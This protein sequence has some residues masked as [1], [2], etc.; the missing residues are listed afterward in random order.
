[1]AR[2]IYLLGHE[3]STF[4]GGL[5]WNTT[6][7][8]FYS[9]A[10]RC[11]IKTKSNSYASISLPALYGDASAEGVWFH[12]VVKREYLQDTGGY[13]V[14]MTTPN[15]T[16]MSIAGSGTYGYP[17][18]HFYPHESGTAVSTG[19]IAELTTTTI[20]T[21]DIHV[22]TSGGD[23]FCDVWKDGTT[24]VSAQTIAGN[25]NNGV[26]SIVLGDSSSAYH[27]YWSEVALT[28]FDTRGLRVSTLVPNAAGD[29]AEGS[30]AYTDIDE[31]TLDGI[32][33]EVSAVNQRHT[34]LTAG[35]SSGLVINGLS[36]NAYAAT[37]GVNPLKALLR[38][39]GTDYVGPTLKDGAGLLPCQSVY[40]TDP[41]TGLAWASD[42]TAVQFGFKSVA[43]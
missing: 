8:N 21:L 41:S 15:W 23:S 33:V 40:L 14:A 13:L 12:G 17:R 27:A 6:S 24:L 5:G 32:G 9:P 26:R 29:Y 42:L 30:G 19:N 18:V 43:P 31:T 4:V 22:Y 37:D 28:N 7:G 38:I 1:V 3:A 11:A 25:S 20:F 34:F 36:V 10:S 35:V 39:G 2:E 16:A